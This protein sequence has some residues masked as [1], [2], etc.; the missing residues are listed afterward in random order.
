MKDGAR[1]LFDEGYT[2]IPLG[3]DANGFAKRPI[4]NGWPM[5][6][7]DWAIIK[8][9]PWKDAK[10]LGIVLGKASGNLAVIDVDDEELAA[11]MFAYCMRR[12][13][14]PRFV[15]TVRKHCH[16]YVRE[17]ESTPSRFFTYQWQGRAVG[18]EFKSQGNQV[19]APPTPGYTLAEDVEPFACKTIDQ[20]AKSLFAALGM[21]LG[22]EEESGGGY[23]KAWAKRVPE[24]QRNRS[25]Y[26]EAHQLRKAGMD[27]EA[28]LPVL[29]ARFDND[30]EGEW[31]PDMEKT[32]VSAYSKDT[33]LSL[34]TAPPDPCRVCGESVWRFAEDGTP[35]CEE[36]AAREPLEVGW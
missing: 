25:I 16:I 4:V 13:A 20:A 32:I 18:I 3:L 2:P 1:T 36:H 14:L 31:T 28:A 23:P 12:H 19:A 11:A 34:P 10:G 33:S 35:Y 8:G 21:T 27:L 29:R 17:A 6:P 30:Y 24:G 22:A 9:L 15:W 5:L 26:V 7:H